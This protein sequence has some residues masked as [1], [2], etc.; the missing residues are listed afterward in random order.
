MWLHTMVLLTACILVPGAQAGFITLTP[1][2]AGIFVGDGGGIGTNRGAFVTA[3]ADF[4]ITSFGFAISLLPSTTTTLVAQIYAASGLARGP[5]LGTA[6]T[7]I[8]ATGIPGLQFYHVPIFFAF[9]SGQQ[10]DLSIS[11]PNY[12]FPG[13]GRTAGDPSIVSIRYY[14]FDASFNPLPPF[15]IAGLITVRDGEASGCGQCNGL[16]PHLQLNV[17]DQAIPELGTWSLISS[18]LAVLAL[19]R[20]R[21]F[22]KLNRPVTRSW[23]SA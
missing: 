18:G 1:P 13:P 12:V 4:N 14:E 10:Y 7:N 5:L 9:S 22:L 8:M 20:H 6:T 16:L 21:R 3:T 19:S 11:F 2:T 23:L 15:N 17:A